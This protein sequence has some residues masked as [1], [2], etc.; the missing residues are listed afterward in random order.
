MGNCVIGAL[1]HTK[2]A[3]KLSHST[4]HAWKHVCTVLR[5]GELDVTCPGRMVEW[6]KRA[7]WV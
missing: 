6:A 3:G 5:H 4:A 2:G 1:A 7:C